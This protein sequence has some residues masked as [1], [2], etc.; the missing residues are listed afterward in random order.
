MIWGVRDFRSEKA[1]FTRIESEVVSPLETN[2]QTR[3]NLESS[4]NF[5]F[6]RQRA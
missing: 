2:E 3:K 1:V 5:P 4:S 6:E